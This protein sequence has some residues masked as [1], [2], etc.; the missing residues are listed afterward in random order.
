MQSYTQLEHRPGDTPQLFDIDGG[1]VTQNADGKVVRLSTQ[2]QVTAVAPVPIERGARYSFR[3]VCR[4]ATNSPDPSDDAISC[5]I[6]W[7]AADKTLLSTTIIDTILN[8]TVADGRREIRRVVT[9]A[10]TTPTEIEAPAAARY[11]VPWVRSFGINHATDV[12][13]CALER[14]NLVALP[15]AR[16]FYVTMDGSDENPGRALSAPLASITAALARMAAE[17]PNP[18]VAIVHP[19]EYL[20]PPDR[21]IPANCALQGHDLRVTRLILANAAGTAPA[22]GTARRNNMFQMS[23]GIKVRGFTITGLEHEPFTLEGGPPQKGYA[24]VFRPGAVITRSPYIADCSMLHDFT[25]DQM[26]LPIDKAAGNP[27]MPRGGGNILADGSVLSPDSPLRSVVVDSFTAINPNGVGYAISRNAVVQLVSVFTNW[28]RVGLWAHAGGQVTVANSNNTFGDFALV[29]TGFRNTI[30]I[31]GVADPGLIGVF[32]PSADLIVA[33]TDAI[34]TAL[35]ETR[36]PALPGWN[37][38]T[39]A[40]KQLAERDTRTLLRA[41]VNDLKAG[42]DRG[43]Q[44]FAKGLFNWNAEYV[45]ATSLLQLVLDCWE[46]L[47]LALLARLSDPEAG[48]MVSALIALI[49]DVVANPAGYRVAFAS[50]IEATGQQFSNAGSGVNYNALPFGQRGTG[51]NPHPSEAIFRAEGGK[52]FAT[53]STE[54]GDTY[55]GADLRVDF[56]RNTIEGQAFSRGVQNIALPLII[57]IGG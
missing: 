30:R 34:I 42:Q 26:T 13:I 37:G 2:Q 22:S 12:E 40:Q 53:F 5:G 56:E 55:L 21:V 7:L 31:G 17:A 11:A 46:E 24:F 20:V 14:L 6:D 45:F 1:L 27:L 51:E 15:V 16:T 48:A 23:N 44:F 54:L 57:G 4:R 41:I 43:A 32:T 19:G 33:Q 18:C 25:Q 47:R 8:L 29:A 35:M 10:D 36:Y 50:V 38:L 3:A 39:A 9:A 52:V 28:S 49:R